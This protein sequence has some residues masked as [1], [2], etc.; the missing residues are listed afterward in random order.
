MQLT[1]VIVLWSFLFFTGCVTEKS[2]SSGRNPLSYEEVRQDTLLDA[3][4]SKKRQ[5]ATFGEYHIS[6][7]LIAQVP[8]DCW[9]VRQVIR[10][11]DR[12][13]SEQNVS[14]CNRDGK[15]YTTTSKQ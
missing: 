12:L 5:V 2:Q 14:V 4:V 11:Y 10:K 15:F 8:P 6:A 13:E 1:Q 3:V 7:W 9:I